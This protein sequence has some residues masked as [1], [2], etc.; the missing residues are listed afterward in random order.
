MITDIQIGEALEPHFI[1]IRG[2][3]DTALEKLESLKEIMDVEVYKRLSAMVI[4]NYV[5]EKAKSYFG[6]FAS[7][8]GIMINDRYKSLLLFFSND[9]LTTRFKKLNKNTLLSGNVTTARN[10]SVIQGTLFEEYQPVVG[11]E[12]GYMFNE[13]GTE[14]DK[15]LVVKRVDKKIAIPIFE[16]LATAKA[17]PITIPAVEV[18]I[19]LTDEQQLKIR[20]DG[21]HDKD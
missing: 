15:I 12:I 21:T 3:Y 9:G 18:E 13:A 16:I 10:T 11:V 5:L 1:T 8:S 4:N 19:N 14:Y 20:K 2:W 7:E 6:D 17:E